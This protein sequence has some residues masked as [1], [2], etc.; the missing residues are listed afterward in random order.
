MIRRA[1]A[2]VFVL[3]TSIVRFWLMRLSGPRTLERRARWVQETCVRVLRS[4]D[5]RLPC[6]GAGSHAWSWW[7][8][9]I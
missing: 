7:L 9:I 8:R 1:V 2:L 4:M 5:I 6:R 3:V